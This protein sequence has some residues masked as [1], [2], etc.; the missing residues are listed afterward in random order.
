MAPLT[1][2]ELTKRLPALSKVMPMG[3]LTAVEKVL[4]V[5]PGVKV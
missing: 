2:S 4:L 3:W 5:P 1:A